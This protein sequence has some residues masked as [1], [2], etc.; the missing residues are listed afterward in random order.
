MQQE[1]IEMQGE[2]GKSIIKVVDGRTLLSVI[3]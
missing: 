1:L 3:E 2:I